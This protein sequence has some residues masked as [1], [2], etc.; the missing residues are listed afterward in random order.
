MLHTLEYL[1]RVP[2]QWLHVLGITPPAVPVVRAAAS[3]CDHR[4]MGQY[5]I[6][7]VERAIYSPDGGRF[8][9]ASRTWG[10]AGGP[11]R[12]KLADATAAITW[13]Q[14]ESGRGLRIPVAVVGPATA[15]ASEC[16]TALELGRALARMGLAVMAGEGTGIAEAV[17]R[18][19]A[20]SHGFLCTVLGGSDDT[21][22]GE[23]S[24]MVL[25]TGLGS[26]T[27]AL[28]AS[29]CLCMIAIGE[30]VSAMPECAA[31]VRAGKALLLLDTPD[32]IAGA[33][34]VADIAAVL[35]AIADHVLQ[36]AA[37]RNTP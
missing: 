18:G 17:S 35:A 11:A 7:Q 12:G 20:T 2:R 29:T 14:R 21:V 19:V 32:E 9:P 6:H 23:H 3:F 5:H 15:S 30:S 16:A 36:G 10:P 37:P 1:P 26:A 24:S 22:A 34:R 31:V 8:D 25:A 28:V 33:Q 27:P 13:L 4:P